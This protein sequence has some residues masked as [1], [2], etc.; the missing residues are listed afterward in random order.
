MLVVAAVL[1]GCSSTPPQPYKL[2]GFWGGVMNY[3]GVDFMVFAMDVST[4]AS[5]TVSGYGIVTDDPTISSGVWVQVTGVTQPTAVN[6]TLT[7]LVN[8]TIQLSGNVEGAV[9]RGT[10]SYASGGYG[11][12][13]RMVAEE[14]VDLLALGTQRRG[15]GATLESLFR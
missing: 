5:G 7:D 9:I 11:G 8:D 3:G 2:S 1:A 4:T 6:L 14:N 13:F 15:E 10:W 12:S